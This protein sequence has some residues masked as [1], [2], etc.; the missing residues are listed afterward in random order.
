MYESVSEN[1]KRSQFMNDAKTLSGDVLFDKYY[2]VTAKV[3]IKT[4]VRKTLLI[5][6]IYSMAKKCLNRVRGR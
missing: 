5:T 6:G 3:K 4:M 2:P 1:S